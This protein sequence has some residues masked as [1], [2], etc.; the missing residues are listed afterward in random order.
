VKLILIFI[1]HRER[2]A[3]SYLLTNISYLRESLKGS[4]FTH[5]KTIAFEGLRQLVIEH[6]DEFIRLYSNRP[7][8]FAP[9]AIGRVNPT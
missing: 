4:N 8:W 7:D 3:M 1:T 9:T 5:M 2:F 6:Q